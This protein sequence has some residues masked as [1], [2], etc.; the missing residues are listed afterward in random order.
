MGLHESLGRRP[1]VR[2]HA[3]A[4]FLD[5]P[6]QPRRNG[7]G[8]LARVRRRGEDFTLGRLDGLA[9]DVDEG[10]RRGRGR[11]RGLGF[12]YLEIQSAT[13]NAPGFGL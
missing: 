3:R 12:E 1:H 10:R 7:G 2:V 5:D 8:Y 11:V 6:P 13:F 4:D 9:R